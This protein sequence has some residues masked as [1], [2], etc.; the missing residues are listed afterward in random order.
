MT[1]LEPVIN[2][3]KLAHKGD[4]CSA[5]PASSTMLWV[6]T[7]PPPKPLNGFL[8]QTQSMSYLWLQVHVNDAL[9]M[10]VRDGL[11]SD[12]GQMVRG[13]GQTCYDHPLWCEPSKQ[14]QAHCAAV[15]SIQIH[16]IRQ[17]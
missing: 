6:G 1:G 8:R 7:L 2:A 16:Q 9:G 3:T 14:R 13:L 17:Q 11:S 15:H 4:G 12:D 5:E 10:A